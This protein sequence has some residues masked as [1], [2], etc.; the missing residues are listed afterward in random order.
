M[1]VDEVEVIDDSKVGTLSWLILFISHPEYPTHHM[2]HLSQ[3]R[4]ARPSVR[5]VS[6][7]LDDN[8]DDDDIL[9]KKVC[10]S[11]LIPNWSN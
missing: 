2:Q 10:T 4:T 5:D 6:V 8:D 3:N 11:P 7:E 9:P 1:D